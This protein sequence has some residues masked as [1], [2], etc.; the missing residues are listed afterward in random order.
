MPDLKI[1]ALTAD[2]TPTSDDLL[3]SVNDPVGTPA[4]RQITCGNAIQRAHG[5][6][7]GV[8]VVDATVMTSAGEGTSGEVLTSN[9]V[10]VAP[11]FQ[12]V[13]GTGD[14]VGPASSTDNAIARFNLATGKVIQN[15]GVLI[16]D[17]DNITGITTAVI[18]GASSLTLGTA[19]LNTGAVIYQNS[20]NANTFTTQSGATSASY[21]V[22]WPVAQG[23]ASTFLQNDGAGVLTWVVGV[24]GNTLDAAYD[25][26][27]A[28][29]GRTI[30]VDTGAVLLAGATTTADVFQ[31]TDAT[32][33]T[34]SA[35]SITSTS[36]STAGRN[37]TEVFNNSASASNTVTMFLLQA[38]DANCLFVDQNG[39]AAALVIDTEA[40]TAAAIFINSPQ[41][42]TGDILALTNADS[43]TTG[44]IANLSSA[45]ASSSARDLLD[46]FNSNVLATGAT[47]MRLRQAS[48]NQC[49]FLDQDGDGTAIVIDSE[50]G[51]SDVIEIRTPQITSGAV[52]RIDDADALTIGE[53]LAIGSNSADTGTRSLID[54]FNDNVLATGATCLTIRQDST[55]DAIDINHVG[56]GV[57][58]SVTA[59]R[60]ENPIHSANNGFRLPVSTAGPTAVTGS[61]DGDL[62]WDTD[63]KALFAFDG[64][65]FVRMNGGGGENFIN[66]YDT[67]T[68]TVSVVNVFQSLNFQFDQLIDGWTHTLSTGTFG[69]NQ[70]GVYLV[71]IVAHM[72]KTGGGADTA[73]IRATFNAVEVASSISELD[74][75]SAGDNKELTSNFFV[76]ATTG[77]DLV[78]EFTG[79]STGV[80]IQS[81]AGAGGTTQTSAAVTIN[82]IS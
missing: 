29:A 30:T 54:L 3:V 13:A 32:L 38:A 40:T 72:E 12:V 80:A 4:N 70:S 41:Q 49:F 66:S 7:N 5:L 23:A 77:Q 10:G 47:V 50:A 24:G 34:N 71:T 17:T 2:A 19:S 43:L 59:G 79:S 58:I 27:G 68:Q 26:G 9:G 48:S 76:N 1:S 20:T 21:T 46:I 37:L 36:T 16:D 18:D 62:V 61:A 56:G 45:S 22:T 65:S 35:L 42:T 64:T 11:T 14:V 44:G 60:I 57:A 8:A 53:I 75:G 55:N 33:T 15:S 25:Q 81:V 69:C 67:T 28:G 63:N 31:I 73:K 82:R 78:I 52:I 51:V 39:D 74:I 6:A